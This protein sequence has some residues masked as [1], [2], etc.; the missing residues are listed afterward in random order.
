MLKCEVINS[1]NS[2]RSFEAAASLIA[3]FH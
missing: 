3:L 1:E 2:V